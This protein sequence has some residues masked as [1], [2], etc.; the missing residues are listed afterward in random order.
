MGIKLTVLVE[1]TARKRGILAE[2]GLSFWIETDR[3]KILFD[4]GQ[5]MA[6]QNNLK[7]LGFN[8]DLLDAI[9]LSHGHYD[10]TGGLAQTLQ[11]A[12][13]PNLYAHPNALEPKF[14]RNPDG[15]S[16]SIGISPSDKQ[17]ALENSTLLL[18][19]EKL[20][21][22]DGIYLTGAIPRVTDFEDTGGAFFTDAE[23]TLPDEL[24]DDQA[25]FI[26]TEKGTM[27]VLG[28]AHS[29]IINTLRH[30]QTLTDNQP[31]HTVIGGMHLLHANA[32]RMDQ[33][34]QELRAL[35]I[36]RLLPCH[37]TGF[38]ATLRLWNE[39]PKTT[40]PC[41]VGTVLKM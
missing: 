16:R 22:G 38:N 15:S 14:A 12:N 36:Q 2:H 30:I 34:L 24:P 1:N 20:N 7:Q 27:V 19:E 9:V 31:I 21:L 39:F 11:S 28:C 10:H 3:Q 35:H 8:P 23:C 25:L 37:C 6:L 29:G 5:G 41:A 18:A 32:N 4:T 33:T 40:L 17:A 13:R 26:E